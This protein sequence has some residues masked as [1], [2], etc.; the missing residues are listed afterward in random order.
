VNYDVYCYQYSDFLDM[1]GVIAA[2]D[3]ASFKAAVDSLAKDGA[4]REDLARQQR[5]FSASRAMVDGRSG[6]RMLALFERLTG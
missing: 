6:E 1:P 4:R 5:E 3:L 2:G